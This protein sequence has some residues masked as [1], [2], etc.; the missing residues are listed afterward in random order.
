EVL[1]KH[2]ERVRIFRL[3]QNFPPKAWEHGEMMSG[4]GTPDLSLRIG[5]PFYFT[6]ELFFQPRGGNDVAAEVVELVD[7][8]GRIETTVKEV[9][10]E[11]FP[12][13]G[14][15][16]E[17][18]DEPLLLGVAPDRSHLDIEIN[19]QKVTLKPGEWSDWVR[20]QFAYNPLLKLHGIGRF[21]LISLDPE[22]RLYLSPIQ[23]DPTDLP[24]IVDITT[25]RKY[26]K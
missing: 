4:L 25:P 9:P 15:E 1:G 22:V 5:K 14:G 26:V 7:N 10:N 16:L 2:G 17:Y 21:R 24:P 18:L 6:S 19:K 13:K 12:K 3:P 20:F 8:K 11:L 23:F